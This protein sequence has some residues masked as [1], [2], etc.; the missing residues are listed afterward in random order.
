MAL[1]TRVKRGC[2][3]DEAGQ[4]GKSMMPRL[5]MGGRLGPVPHSPLL[6]PRRKKRQH[7]LVPPCQGRDQDILP[8]PDAS[9]SPAH[10]SSSSFFRRRSR[11]QAG[12]LASRA[13]SSS[14]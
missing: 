5:G 4:A 10:L 7:H 11:L 2:A 14:S 12:M 8:S 9:G 1:Q 13:S 6:F 3:Q